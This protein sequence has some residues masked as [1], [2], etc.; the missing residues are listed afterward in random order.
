[1]STLFYGKACAF[2]GILPANPPL[3]HVKSFKRVIS[4]LFCDFVI[5]FHV[6]K[7]LSE[8][9]ACLMNFDSL[10]KCS[11]THPGYKMV[12]QKCVDQRSWPISVD[13][14]ESNP[15][16]KKL[17]VELRDLKRENRELEKELGKARCDKDIS[18]SMI[19]EGCARHA[20]LA[21]ENKLL[22]KDNALLEMEIFDLKRGISEADGL[23]RSLKF[24]A[25]N[26]QAECVR[27]EGEKN[28]L[29][30]ANIALKDQNE[31]LREDNAV[32]EAALLKPRHAPTGSL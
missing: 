32:L 21:D 20:R 3:F 13:H 26:A 1:M 31:T 23:K 11:T 2:L 19:A 14:V 18:D 25:D 22:R 16:F 30:R 8:A 4:G 12:S 28:A 6:T 7:T 10:V 9:K 17:K 24:D 15:K 5:E 27:L 29:F